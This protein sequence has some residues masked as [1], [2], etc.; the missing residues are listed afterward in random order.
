MKIKL[1]K[2]WEHWCQSQGLRI[3]GRRIGK[4]RHHWLYLKGRG[5]VWRVNCFGNLQ[6]GDPLVEFDRWALCQVDEVIMPKSKAEFKA[7]V[8]QLLAAVCR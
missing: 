2:Q 1:P 7:A 6:R 4:K 8:E 5:F 3:H